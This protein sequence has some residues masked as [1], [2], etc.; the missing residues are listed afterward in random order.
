M[1]DIALALN[2]LIINI[3]FSEL[4][5]IYKVG[6]TTDERLDGGQSLGSSRMPCPCLFKSLHALTVVYTGDK[7]HDGPRSRLVSSICDRVVI[8]VVVVLVVPFPLRYIRSRG[9]VRFCSSLL[10][11]DPINSCTV[12]CTNPATVSRLTFPLAGNRR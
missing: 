12:A 5:Y 7:S 2:N 10:T 6:L 8:V 11:A 4:A 3:S 9:P 1:R